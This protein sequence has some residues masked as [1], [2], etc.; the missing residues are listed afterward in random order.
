MMQLPIRAQEK[1]T[2]EQSEPI[3]DSIF[4]PAQA[5]FAPASPGVIR[6]VGLTKLSQS[7][8]LMQKGFVIFVIG[9]TVKRLWLFYD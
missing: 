2:R 8:S 1:W 3:E 9:L 6:R 7:A 5:R 4:Y